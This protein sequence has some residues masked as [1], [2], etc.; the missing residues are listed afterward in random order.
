M[1]HISYMSQAHL[2]R[3]IS[4]ITEAVIIT[5]PIIQKIKNKTL[6]PQVGKANAFQPS[7]IVTKDHIFFL[8]AFVIKVDSEN[9]KK[10]HEFDTRGTN[11]AFIN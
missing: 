5:I 6:F 8:M 3:L 10:R 7:G 9:D 4:F 11:E 2:N 1:T